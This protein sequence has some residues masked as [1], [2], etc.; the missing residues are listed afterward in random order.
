MTPIVLNAA[1]QEKF[2]GTADETIDRIDGPITVKAVLIL[3][4]SLVAAGEPQTLLWRDPG[5]I[6]R[7][8]LAAGPAGVANAPKAPF[9]FVEE[10]SGG[11]AP[12]VTVTDGRGKKWMVKFGE[13]AKAETFA[14]RLAWA[15]GYPT[16]ISY[17]VRAGKIEGASDLR[18]TKEF[19]DPNGV[20]RGARFQMFDGDHMRQIPGGKLDLN[21]RRDDQ[22]ELNGLKLLLLLLANWDV[23]TQNTG[24]FD[25]GGRRFSV[26]TDWGASL[27]DP[28]SVDVSARKWDCA[29]FDK[30]TRSLV[31]GVDG[32]YVSFN[33]DQYAARHEDALSEG[34]RVD[35]MR[36][37]MNRMGKLTDAQLRNG[38]L[39]SG[40][41]S[42][43]AAC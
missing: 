22:R 5:P 18:R 6:E 38:L 16:R 30:R 10:V 7:L 28:A 17:Y 40:A 37:F 36:W 43:E 23:K 33:Y 25:I 1:D 42:T 2:V 11:I 26:I 19:V 24:V 15:S 21:R 14:S 20:F 32:G 13:E 3:V 27:G 29:A 8:D 9:S 34:I 12:K 4:S 41:T 31:D 39:A 35:D